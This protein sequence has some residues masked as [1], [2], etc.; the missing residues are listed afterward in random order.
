MV[1]LKDLKPLTKN[2]TVLGQSIEVR[3]VSLDTIGSMIERFPILERV[4]AGAGVGQ[5]KDFIQMAPKAAAAFIA[6]GCGYQDDKDAEAV[7]LS[8]D[9]DTQLE[10]IT[11]ISE[12]TFPNGYGPFIL[13]LKGRVQGLGL[14]ASGKA[15]V[16]NTPPT[17]KPSSRPATASKTSGS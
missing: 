2:V 13:K 8:L 10:L 3:G 5:P 15:P 9:P 1:G 6:A 12:V 14:G 17:S 4:L 16:M 7:A 11:A